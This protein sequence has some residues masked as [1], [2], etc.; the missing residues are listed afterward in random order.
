MVKS[1]QNLFFVTL[2]KYLTTLLVIV[3]IVSL[4]F[5][6]FSNYLQFNST[7]SITNTRWQKVHIQVKD[8]Q[9]S[10]TG[11]DH[12]IFD[13]YLI[14]GQSR[15]FTVSN[16]DDIL[17][18]RDRDPDHADGVHFTEWTSANCDESSVCIVNNP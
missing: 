16:G 18:R 7:V 15:T 1:Y 17:Y 6:F 2:R 4:A 10:G 8:G 13:Q 11:V 3:V 12:I 14:E 9:S 5:L